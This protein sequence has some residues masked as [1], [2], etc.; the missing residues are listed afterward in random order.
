MCIHINPQIP[1]HVP[2]CI[3]MQDD[4][5]QFHSR[6]TCKDYYSPITK[7]KFD[8]ALEFALQVISLL[9]TTRTSCHVAVR[10]N[11]LQCV[12]VCCRVLQC[13]AGNFSHYRALFCFFLFSRVCTLSHLRIRFLLL[14]VS[15]S[16]FFLPHSHRHTVSFYLSLFLSISYSLKHTHANTLIQHP[17][18]TH[19]HS[20][21][22]R[23]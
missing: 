10:C 18:H 3:H 11:V 22:W 6:M 16:L 20:H 4:P 13:V 8:S 9:L 14:G 12:A 17:T 2:S 21:T 19:A 15:R 23:G 1:T 5:N 7:A